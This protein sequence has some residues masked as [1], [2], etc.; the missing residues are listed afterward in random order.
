MLCFALLQHQLTPP[1]AELPAPGKIGRTAGG[2]VVQSPAE[3]VQLAG[4]QGWHLSWKGAELVL[5][6]RA[7][8]H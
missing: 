3:L 4:R 7:A 2:T 1:P 5:Q 6:Q 8:E